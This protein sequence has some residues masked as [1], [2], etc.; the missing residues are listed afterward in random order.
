MTTVELASS[1]NILRRGHIMIFKKSYF[2]TRR[3]FKMNL[4]FMTVADEATTYSARREVDR[5]PAHDDFIA[6]F[7]DLKVEPNDI[8]PAYDNGQSYFM[9]RGYPSTFYIY[10]IFKRQWRKVVEGDED[11]KLIAKSM[12]CPKC[13]QINTQIMRALIRGKTGWVRCS[14]CEI[15]YHLQTKE[16]NDDSSH[17]KK[18]GCVD[19]DDESCECETSSFSGDEIED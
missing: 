9:V 16:I 5:I 13:G 3:Q 10:C 17:V 2:K 19:A 15:T 8:I 7:G 12:G 4:Q 6:Q 1:D 14:P 18:C 11:Y